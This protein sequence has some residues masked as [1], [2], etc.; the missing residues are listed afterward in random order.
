MQITY[1]GQVPRPANAFQDGQPHI[2]EFRLAHAEVEQAERG[3]AVVWIEFG[4]QP[5]R[6]CVQGEQLDDRQRVALLAA[7]GGS[8]VV[9]QLVA[10]I[11]VDEW[12]HGCCAQG[13][14]INAVSVLRKRVDE[15]K[16][17]CTSALLRQIA[18]ADSTESVGTR[19]GDCVS[20]EAM[21]SVKAAFSI[22]T[23]ATNSSREDFK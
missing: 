8:T 14:T 5:G 19:I 3:I 18:K 10:V 16:L 11:V 20:T 6:V 23:P 22:D 9:Q 13:V 21:M 15:S 2:T 17:E 1:N 7:R 4:Q 12:F